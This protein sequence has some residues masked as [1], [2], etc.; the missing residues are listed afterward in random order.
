MIANGPGAGGSNGLV[1]KGAIRRHPCPV[2]G[3]KKRIGR[4][5]NRKGKLRSRSDIAS[6]Q[7]QLKDQS[8]AVVWI[9]RRRG[10]TDRAGGNIRGTSGSTENGLARGNCDP[11]A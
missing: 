11:G 3:K 1:Q 4:D 2:A 10:K 5:K 7:K 6:T 8:G 9:Q